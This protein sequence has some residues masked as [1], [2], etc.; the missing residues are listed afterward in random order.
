MA[1]KIRVEV[2]CDLPH[3]KE[4]EGSE[5][6]LFGFAGTAYE[7]DACTKHAKEL[8]EAMGPYVDCGRRSTGPRRVV[9]S[10]RRPAAGTDTAEIRAWAK[11]AGHEISE[12]GRIPQS[13]VREYEATH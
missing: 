1:Q 8:T 3:A 12:R 6:I 5:T 4:T 13:I 2:L 11:Q 7:I 9:R 10:R